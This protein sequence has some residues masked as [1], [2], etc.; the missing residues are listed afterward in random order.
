MYVHQMSVA[1]EACLAGHLLAVLPEF[2]A[3][4]FVREGELRHLAFG[5]LPPTALY[6]TYARAHAS[7]ERVRAVVAAVAEARATA[8]ERDLAAAAPSVRQVARL[9]ARTA[10]DDDDWLAGGDAL[11]ARGENRAAHAL[12]DEALHAR[13]TSGGDSVVDGARHVGRIARLLVSE[14]KYEEAERRCSEALVGL[15]GTDALVAA[16]LE[17]TAALAC[18]FR[19]DE[20]RAR[21]GLDRAR[22]FAS[23]EL[24]HAGRAAHRMR[25]LVQRTE[26]NLLVALGRHNDAIAAYG[27]GA[28]AAA[29]SGD[30]WEHSIA[31]FNLAEAHAM[32]GHLDGV[33]EFLDAATREKTQIGDRWGLAHVHQV[34]A[35]VEL[36]NQ[37]A[38]RAIEEVTRALQLS[39]GLGDPK[40]VSACNATLGEVLLARGE[41]DEA[42]RAFDL[43]RTDA[44]QCGARA[45]TI[46]ALVGLSA[47]DLERGKHASARRCAEK[48]LALARQGNARFIVARTLI[49]L[50]DVASAEERHAEAA[51]LYRDALSDKREQGRFL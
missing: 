44:E 12:Y 8:V 4:A 49:A 27:K 18:C 13:Q 9:P 23:V 10:T 48:A 17:A 25:A 47:V 21:E 24:P 28:E 41:R 37:H 7:D 34:R 20:A 40:L 42:R 32:L 26:G 1:L 22:A 35:R 3:R 29:A 50:A 31:L 15:A 2:V 16:L 45:E 19:G 5:D 43:A 38:D 36:G 51:A 33:S 39:A 30:T 14:G 6:A 46:R 11:F